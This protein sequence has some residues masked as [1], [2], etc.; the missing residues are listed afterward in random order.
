[1]ALPVWVVGQVLTAADVNK[2]FVPILVVKGSDQS[3]TSSTT[4]VND[5][6]LVVPVAANTLYIFDMVLQYVANATARMNMQF[7]GPA[8]A[9]M[10]SGLMGFNA[11]ASY[12]ATTRGL[13]NPVVF[14]GN[15]VSQV[16]LFWRGNL[17]TAGTAGNFQ[18]QWA[19]SVSN[20]TAC[21]VKTGS[22]LS[23]V[24]AG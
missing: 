21:T 1:M 14:D 10:Q 20:G 18:F 2:W 16:P 11:A 4:L 3:V 23:I 12:G 6:A 13:A 17:Q 24:A 9:T 19:Q 22:Q 15:G 8:G 5:T 7:T